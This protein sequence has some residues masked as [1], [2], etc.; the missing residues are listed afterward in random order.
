MKFLKDLPIYAHFS[1]I[2]EKLKTEEDFVVVAPTGSG[3]SLGLPLKLLKDN[4]GRGKI[5]VVQPRR[6]ACFLMKA[7]K[8]AV[9]CCYGGS[10]VL[11]A[12]KHQTGND[13]YTSSLNTFHIELVRCYMQILCKR[14]HKLGLHGSK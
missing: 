7:M 3:K 11:H 5:L 6:I 8:R 1:E 9:D 2:F 12:V 10:I 13:M 4:L 14:C